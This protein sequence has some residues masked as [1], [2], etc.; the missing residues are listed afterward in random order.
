MAS[1][2]LRR[3]IL[4]LYTD[5]Q[6]YVVAVLRAIA[7]IGEARVVVYC[8]K[9]DEM[10]P[11]RHPEMEGVEIRYNDEL[12]GEEIRARAEDLDP[13]LVYVSGWMN[14]AYMPAVKRMRALGKPVVSG[15]DNIWYGNLKQKALALFGARWLRRRFSHMWVAGPMQYAFAT[16]LGYTYENVLYNLYTA[17]VAPFH[18][19][20]ESAR[21]EKR[22]S[23]PRRILYVGRLIERKGVD[24]LLDA[25]LSLPLEKRAGWTL[26][27]R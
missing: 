8:K 4:F 6:G 21:A 3:K 26:E 20:R 1:G 14:K 2:I 13:D 7:T 16:R 23:Y 9:P 17:N 22:A 19:E 24:I 25:Y 5:V 18:A 10:T 12:S 11:Y 27:L 15:L